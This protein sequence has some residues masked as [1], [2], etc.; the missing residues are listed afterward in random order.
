MSKKRQPMTDQERAAFDESIDR[1]RG[2]GRTVK[3]ARLLAVKQLDASRQADQ[4]MQ[5]IEDGEPIRRTP[6][7]RSPLPPEMNPTGAPF[8]CAACG[9]WRYAVERRGN[10]CYTCT[11]KGPP[12]PNAQA[13]T[14]PP[15]RPEGW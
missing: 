5:A 14:L 11:R 15:A 6:G 1:L 13:M 7:T 2:E 8:L 3:D 9:K 4:D 12:M 10:R